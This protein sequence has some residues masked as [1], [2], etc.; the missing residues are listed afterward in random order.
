MCKDCCHTSCLDRG[1]KEEC[2]HYEPIWE[3]KQQEEM[4][5]NTNN[6]S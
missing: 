3:I 6:K 5:G 1:K 2:K 4:N